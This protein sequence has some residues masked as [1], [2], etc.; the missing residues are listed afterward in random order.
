M[1]SERVCESCRLKTKINEC[2]SVNVR[3]SGF[4]LDEDDEE[5]DERR[6]VEETRKRCCARVS[7]E[8]RN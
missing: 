7:I 8:V 5:W 3:V 2:V 1:T 6:R 4:E